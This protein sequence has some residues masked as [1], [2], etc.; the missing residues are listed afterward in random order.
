MTKHLEIAST[1][2]LAYRFSGFELDCRTRD[3]RRG[4]RSIAMPARCFECLHHLILMR[5]RAVSRDELAQAVF[6]RTN[7]SDAQLGQVVLRARRVLGDDGHKQNF[8]RTVPRYGFR[9][10]AEVEEIETSSE[11]LAT[12]PPTMSAS[13]QR[14]VQYQSV[15]VALLVVAAATWALLEEVPFT[16]PLETVEQAL[17]ESQEDFVAGHNQH[18]LVALDH[19]LEAQGS[20]LDAR[21]RARALVQRG[22]FEIRLGRHA[23]AERDFSNAILLLDAEADPVLLGRAYNARGV[24]QSALGLFGGARQDFGRARKLL[25]RKG[26]LRS[27]GWVDSNLGMLR[28]LSVGPRD[29]QAA[30]GGVSDDAH[31]HP[32]EPTQDP[33]EELDT[34]LGDATGE[35]LFGRSRH[36]AA[37]VELAAHNR[38]QLEW[39]QAQRHAARAW[40]LRS[41]ARAAEE[42]SALFVSVAKTLLGSGR[43]RDA[44]A[45]LADSSGLTHD[46]GH[47]DALRAE[48]AWRS[49]DSATALAFADRALSSAIPDTEPA[50]LLRM[51]RQRLE[52]VSAT[53]APSRGRITAPPR[54]DESVDAWLVRALAAQ[55]HGLALDAGTAY[56]QAVSRAEED[57]SPAQVVAVAKSYLPWLIDQ[58]AFAQARELVDRLDGWTAHDYD[59]ALVVLSAAQ[60]TGDWQRA[61]AAALNAR[62]LAG[63]RWRP[64]LPDASLT[65]PGPSGSRLP[66]PIH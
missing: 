34:F 65:R 12:L 13:P 27:V 57:H 31:H 60:A 66:S 55:S 19:M 54:E 33:I 44:R 8:I 15:S 43:L 41:E 45:L 37:E 5:E 17:V 21:G 62:R 11:P 9:W 3:L 49:G 20:R 7:V 10:L 52:L 48:L 36:L 29:S 56:R 61:R 18:G 50:E 46:D 40:A 24:A 39:P 53:D 51:Q 22:R 16:P 35:G 30:G 14:H 26:E 2:A 23:D 1:M 58:R 64:I 28:R 32:V 4:H 63:E 59:A 25:A 38:E 42:R 47:L 6:G